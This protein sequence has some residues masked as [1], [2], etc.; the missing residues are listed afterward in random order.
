MRLASTLAAMTV[1]V[2]LGGCVLPP[3]SEPQLKALTQEE[4]GLGNAAA[5]EVDR[6]WEQY[7]DPQFSA[8]MDAGLEHNPSLQ[9]AMARFT[10]AQAQIPGVAA[11][12]RPEIDLKGEEIRQRYPERFIYP[13]PFGGGVYWQG[14][15]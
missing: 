4:V 9:Q 2:A 1:V 11:A 12:R 10:V 13:P 15:I 6:W 8:L 5:P 3:K 14:S 7:G